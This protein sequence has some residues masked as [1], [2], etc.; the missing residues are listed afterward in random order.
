[1]TAQPPGD[2]GTHGPWGPNRSHPRRPA[3]LDP[4]QADQIEGGADPAKRTAAAHRTASAV[5][6][7]G[8][9]GVDAAEVERL[10]RLVETEGVE[11]VA[12]LWA[13]SGPD[14]LPGALWRLY[15]LREWIRRSPV[16]VARHYALGL[17]RAHVAGVVAG[18]AEPPTPGE[19][20]RVADAVLSGAISA[21][22]D[23]ALDR[24]AAFYRVVGTGLALDAD[25]H[26]LPHGDDAER[27]TRRAG[28]LVRTA[29]ELRESARRAR[30]GTLE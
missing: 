8:H 27:A 13:D 10:V 28:N 30:A 21:D 26:D 20:Q 24:A 19:M 25:L 16:E 7:R 6:R 3:S 4:A 12:E 15:A 1:M 29:E 2:S 22:L 5:L 23:V 14:T 9:D 18:A 17:Q 11:V